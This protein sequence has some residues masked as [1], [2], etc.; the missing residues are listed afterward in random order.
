MTAAIKALEAELTSVETLIEYH[1]A[2]LIE[3]RI[4]HVELDTSL[5]ILRVANVTTTVEG[6]SVHVDVDHPPR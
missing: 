2:Q 6:E 3:A 1:R 4:R 5:N